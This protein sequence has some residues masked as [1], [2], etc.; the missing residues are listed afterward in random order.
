[1][2]EKN[3]LKDE[4]EANYNDYKTRKPIKLNT[5]LSSFVRPYVRNVFFFSK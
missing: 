4:C 2:Q 3:R 5:I 1:M